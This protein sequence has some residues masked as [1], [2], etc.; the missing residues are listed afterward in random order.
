[1]NTNIFRSR[2]SRFL[3]GVSANKFRSYSRNTLQNHYTIR[4]KLVIAS[5]GFSIPL[6]TTDDE[7]PEDKLIETI[8]RSILCIQREEYGK[9]EQMLHLALRMAQDQNSQKGITYIYDVMANLAME[10]NQFQKAEKLFVDVMRRLVGEDY[11]Q[12]GIKML[13]ISSKIAHMAHLQGN[14]DKALEGFNWCLDKINEKLKASSVDE[15]ELKELLGMTT[16]WLG[17]LL[18][19][20]QAFEQAKKCFEQALFICDEFYGKK[21]AE[22]IIILNNLCVVHTSVSITFYVHKHLQYNYPK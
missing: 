16:N 15:R 21:N 3:L 17:Q 20:T 8:K 13:H 14:I 9:A 6:F 18:M 1:M 12:D 22:A 7:T 11:P 19:E 10:R 4:P 2:I 5:L